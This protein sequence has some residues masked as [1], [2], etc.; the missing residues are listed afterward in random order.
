MLTPYQSGGVPF[1]SDGFP[2]NPGTPPINKPHPSLQ[3]G[4]NI[5]P[6]IQMRAWKGDSKTSILDVSVDENSHRVRT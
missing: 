2:L 1:K 4:A 3:I 5:E 6:K